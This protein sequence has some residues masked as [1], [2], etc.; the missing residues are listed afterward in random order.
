[1]TFLYQLSKLLVIRFSKLLIALFD[2]RAVF[3]ILSDI[4]LTKIISTSASINLTKLDGIVNNLSAPTISSLSITQKNPDVATNVTITGSG[5][6]SIPLVTFQNT[7]TGARVT[8][9]TVTFTS[10]TSLV[11]KFPADQTVGT[12]KVIVENPDGIAVRSSDSIINSAAPTWQ[13]A[14]PLTSYE[15]GDT[16]N[17][18]LL[19]YDDDSTAVSS[20]SLQSGTL[21]SGV[22]LSG[23]SSIGSLTGTAPTVTADTQYSFTIRATDNESQTTDKAF[24]MT[25]T[26]YNLESLMFNQ[27]DDPSLTRTPSSTGNRRK[28]TWSGWVKRASDYGARNMLFGADNSADS[29][30]TYIRFTDD[31]TIQ[32]Y[33]D[34]NNVLEANLNTSAKYRDSSAWYHIVWAVDTTQATSSDRVKIYV[35]GVQETSWGTET[36]PAQ[37]VEFRLAKASN[38]QEIGAQSAGSHFDGLMSHIHFIDGTQYQASDFGETDS[39]TGEWK[40][41]TSPSVTYGTNGFFI[42]KDGNSVTDQSSNSNNWTVANGTLTNTDDCPS[43]VFCTLNPLFNSAG[44]FSGNTQ[45]LSFS[46]GNKSRN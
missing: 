3:L 29:N 30:A 39:T 13:T 9:T 22:T 34:N 19:A 17:E 40:I 41:K 43:N 44:Y 11:A 24:N 38:P 37:N 5:Y 12:Y 10:S 1:M 27:D 33:I 26:N 25:I 21:P 28:F 36:Y 35:N 46:N 32:A 20:Y 15:E 31:Q 45:S 4:C 2:Q 23:D 7:S 42:L 6:V 8:A 18:T 16:V 14:S